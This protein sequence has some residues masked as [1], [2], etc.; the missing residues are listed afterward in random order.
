MIG[1]VEPQMHSGS[2]LSAWKNDENVA[3]FAARTCF[4][5]ETCFKKKPA[6]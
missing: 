6:A 2:R 1:S 5:N 4:Q 3:G